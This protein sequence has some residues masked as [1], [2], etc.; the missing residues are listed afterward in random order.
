MLFN[1]TSI[2]VPCKGEGANTTKLKINL[3]YEG[4]DKQCEADQ[5]AE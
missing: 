1:I 5:H 4:K 2:Q 3:K